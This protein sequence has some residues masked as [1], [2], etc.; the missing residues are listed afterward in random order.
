MILYDYVEK[1]VI[2]KQ[3]CIDYIEKWPIMVIFLYN[4]YIIVW[5]LYMG[6]IFKS[7]FIQNYNESCYKD[8]PV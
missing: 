3:K 5:I 1:W 6:L 4:I 2:S 8:V 7:S